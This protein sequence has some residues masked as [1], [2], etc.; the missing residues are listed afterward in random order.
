M[1]SL[2][3]ARTKKRVTEMTSAKYA[4]YARIDKK[5]ANANVWDSISSLGR[6]I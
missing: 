6:R 3:A 2:L 1:A 5:I 4:I